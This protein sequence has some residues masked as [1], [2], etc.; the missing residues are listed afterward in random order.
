MRLN[1]LTGSGGRYALTSD[2]HWA[3]IGFQKSWYSDRAELRFTVNLLVVRRTVWAELVE[4]RPHY[5][6]K[7][8]PLTHYGDSVRQER[9]G[10]LVD[11]R[12]DKWWRI[13]PGQ[14]LAVV[15]SDV[16]SNLTEH[17]L[18]WLRS[19]VSSS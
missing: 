7:P 11:D 12:E 3:L 9:I 5:G 2:T 18:P 1:G 14:D 17:G 15:E 8:S 13:Y 16:L 19:Q 10:M 4:Q 6:A